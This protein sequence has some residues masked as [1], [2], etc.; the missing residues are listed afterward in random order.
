MIQSINYG[1]TLK[2]FF[3][4]YISIAEPVAVEGL[5]FSSAF[6]LSSDFNASE[7]HRSGASF[8]L[9]CRTSG[10]PPPTVQWFSEGVLIENDTNR[11]VYDNV[12]LLTT[13]N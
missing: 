5:R 2:L 1:V 12:I 3:R 10:Q 4:N 13:I 7:A 9:H 11:L 6:G 8:E